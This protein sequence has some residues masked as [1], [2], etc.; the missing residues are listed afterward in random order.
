MELFWISG[1]IF[2]AIFAM[3]FLAFIIGRDDPMN[4]VYRD[5]DITG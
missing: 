3:I 5:E 1:G 4:E 2:L